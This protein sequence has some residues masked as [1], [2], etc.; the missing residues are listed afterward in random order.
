MVEFKTTDGHELK[1]NS[2]YYTE[3]GEEVYL[4]D[5]GANSEGKSFYVVTYLYEGE[6]VDFKLYP[7]GHTEINYEYSHETCEEKVLYQIFKEVPMVRV[8]EEYRNKAIEVAQLTVGIGELKVLQKTLENKV[9]ALE[10]E[11]RPLEVK[12]DNLLKAIDASQDE[13][14]EISGQVK[15]LREEHRTLTKVVAESE[16]V[17]GDSVSVSKEELMRL[18][19]RET[20]LDALEAGGVDNW[21]WYDESRINAGLADD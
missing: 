15:E 13:Y 3:F 20:L 5:F 19:E 10:S 2:Y 9:R 18:Q 4:V 16:Q 11:L 21:E 17:I 14:D 6:G 8:A 12:K 7:E 1:K